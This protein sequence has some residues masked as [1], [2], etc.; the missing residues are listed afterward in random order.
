M[1]PASGYLFLAWDVFSEDYKVQDSLAVVFENVRFIRATSILP[2][3]PVVFNVK[4]GDSGYFEIT[5]RDA[6]VVTGYIR[7]V[8][9]ESKAHNQLPEPIGSDHMMTTKDIYQELRLRGYNYQ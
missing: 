7:E 6:I 8:P 1:F 5:E 2:S 9:D 4:I 3:D